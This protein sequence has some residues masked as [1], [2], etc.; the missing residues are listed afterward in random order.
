MDFFINEDLAGVFSFICISFMTKKQ[1]GIKKRE[2]RRT[3]LGFK[4]ILGE[5]RH[6]NN[7][8]KYDVKVVGKLPDF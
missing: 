8:E 1:Q 3:S 5:H 4:C 2:K 6:D 7:D